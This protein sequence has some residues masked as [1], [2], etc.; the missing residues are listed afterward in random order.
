MSNIQTTASML[1]IIFLFISPHFLRWNSQQ[2]HFLPSPTWLYLR[3]KDISDYTLIKSYSW[4]NF[5]PHCLSCEATTSKTCTLLLLHQQCV[6]RPSCPLHCILQHTTQY[7][8]VQPTLDLLHEHTRC[9]VDACRISLPQWLHQLI[10]YLLLW[11][12]MA[13]Q[14][15]WAI[16]SL[17]WIHQALD[18][19]DLFG[20][21]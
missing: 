18:M 16:C 19:K 1:A 4:S 20:V 2:K 6:A 11:L 12:K 17:I 9:T 13:H 8:W 10:M 15:W 21:P 7:Y 14:I 5:S 3:K